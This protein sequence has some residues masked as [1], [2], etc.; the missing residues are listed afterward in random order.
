MKA[1]EFDRVI[2]VNLRG[3]FLGCKYAAEQ[4]IGQ[5]R[6]GS[7]VNV[8]SIDALHPSSVGLA[9]YDAS[10][11]GVWGFTKNA[12]SELAPHRIRVNCVAPGMMD[13]PGARRSAV[14]SEVDMEKVMFSFLARIPLGRSGEPDDIARAV[15]FLASELS[16]YMT[17][18]QIVV[19]G[20]YLLR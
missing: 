7:I 19:D 3:V 11:H 6:P 14:V 1:D 4:M 13:A 16:A 8:T 9:H 17:G 12:A 10:K 20:G 15:L 2:D 5:G 18:A